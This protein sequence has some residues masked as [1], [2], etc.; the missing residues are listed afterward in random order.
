M[1]SRYIF[2]GKSPKFWW[3]S[4][5][6]DLGTACIEPD[7]QPKKQFLTGLEGYQLYRFKL[8]NSPHYPNRHG[9]P[10]Y[11]Q[12]ALFH[13]PR[14]GEERKS[15]DKTLGWTPERLSGETF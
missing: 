9:I 2:P 6:S 5:L 11:P 3:N 12:P 10:E 8:N 4:D 15:L 7:E 13:C 14:C 1:V